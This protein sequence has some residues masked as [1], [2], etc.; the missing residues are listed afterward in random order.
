MQVCVCVK[1][2]S[3]ACVR[4]MRRSPAL[5]SDTL[6][7]LFGGCH[8]VAHGVMTEGA[9]LR[10]SGAREPAL[11]LE[12]YPHTLAQGFLEGAVRRCAL[13]LF[14]LVGLPHLGQIVVRSVYGHF[15]C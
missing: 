6:E 4:Q 7:R 10:D 15:F 1:P 12:A 2:I 11:F 14:V 5:G 8:E 9:G 3:E 13:A